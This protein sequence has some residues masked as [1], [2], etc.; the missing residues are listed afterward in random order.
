M[1]NKKLNR[2]GFTLIELLA[3]IVILAIL[4]LLAM[5]S[6]LNIMENARFG[7]FKTEAESIVKAAQTQYA[8]DSITSSLGGNKCYTLDDIDVDNKSG[9]AAKIDI[10]ST[11]DQTTGKT[12]VSYKISFDN[13]SYKTKNDGVEYEKISSLKSSDVDKSGTSLT[14]YSCSGS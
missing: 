13:G 11:T 10:K 4:I 9:K 14:S 8:Q 7:A 1:G 12:T 3:V 2:K 5:P 6:V